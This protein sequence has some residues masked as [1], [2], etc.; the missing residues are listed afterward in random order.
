MGTG[1]DDWRVYLVGY[2]L[3]SSRNHSKLASSGI[4]NNTIIPNKRGYYSISISGSIGLLDDL[5]LVHFYA[6]DQPKVI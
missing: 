6:V 3:T 2:S 4:V 5:E 1:P